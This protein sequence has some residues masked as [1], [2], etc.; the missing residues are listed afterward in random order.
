[1]DVSRPLSAAE[2]TAL[3]QQLLGAANAHDQQQLMQLYR[4]VGEHYF[5]IGDVDQACF[6]YTNGWVI[7]L[8]LGDDAEQSL[9]SVL[10][11]HGRV[12]Q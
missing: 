6:F 11:S 1:M 2:L 9:H 10:A 8:A 3:E 12:P 7:A 5:A 4:R